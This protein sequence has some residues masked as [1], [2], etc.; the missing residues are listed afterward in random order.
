LI[1]RAEEL[2]RDFGLQCIPVMVA[3]RKK[4]PKV[5]FYEFTT[6]VKRN[7]I[8]RFLYLQIVNF[9]SHIPRYQLKN[10][11]TSSMKK[12]GYQEWHNVKTWTLWLPSSRYSHEPLI[13][14]NIFKK[15]I[16]I[17]LFWLTTEQIGLAFGLV[18][19]NYQIGSALGLA[20]IMAIISSQT[21]ALRKSWS[22]EM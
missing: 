16:G 5:Q 12:C 6:I 17:Y 15:S 22:T 9:R 13:P 20:I 21:I 7:Y 10:M 18:T 11:N 3:L 2:G 14:L 8:L 4:K 19:T 1:K